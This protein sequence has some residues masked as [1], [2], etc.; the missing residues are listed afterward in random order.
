MNENK[1]E[2]ETIWD[3][4][5]N[6]NENTALKDKNLFELEFNAIFSAISYKDLQDGFF[7]R[8]LLNIFLSENFF[9]SAVESISALNLIK[10]FLSDKFVISKYSIFFEFKFLSTFFISSL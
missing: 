8:F 3:N 7:G 4:Q 1:G 5:Y 2:L 6:D 10:S 9:L